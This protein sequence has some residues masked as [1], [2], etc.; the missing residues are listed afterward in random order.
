MILIC[1]ICLF[2]FSTMQTVMA[3]DMPQN[4]GEKTPASLQDD[5][6]RIMQELRE[7]S[8]L[9]YQQI[10]NMPREK[11]LRAI[12]RSLNSAVMPSAEF[13]AGQEQCKKV[14]KQ[15]F[16]GFL[17]DKRLFYIR[18]DRLDYI[19]IRRALQRQDKVSALILDFRTGS[20][21]DYTSVLPLRDFLRS[22]KIP[23][24]LLISNGTSGAAELFCASVKSDSDFILIGQPGAGQMFPMVKAELPSGVWHIPVIG[25]Q[26][27]SI[28]AGSVKPEIYF[29]WRDRITEAGLKSQSDPV[30]DGL[31]TFAGD[32][33]VSRLVLRAKK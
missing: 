7:K 5:F 19:A 23:V 16:S 29:S 8:P 13:K 4:T 15:F 17:P 1:F 32:F 24:A 20:G 26:F 3:G 33:L 6:S 2:V 21:D 25:E 22:R 10:Q 28:P 11:A 9:L 18:C 14:K 31:L 12:F 30:R 27:A